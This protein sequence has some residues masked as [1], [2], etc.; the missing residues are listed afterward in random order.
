MRP[1]EWSSWYKQ[2]RQ[3]LAEM[4][5]HILSLDRDTKAQSLIGW[6]LHVRSHLVAQAAKPS[7]HM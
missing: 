4:P 1:D 6:S 2:D 7:I 3:R 5:L